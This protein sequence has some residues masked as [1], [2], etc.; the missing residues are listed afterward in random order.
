MRFALLVAGL[1]SV[2]SVQDD[3]DGCEST[4]KDELPQP[5][6]SLANN[7]PSR[8]IEQANQEFRQDNPAIAIHNTCQTHSNFRIFKFRVLFNFVYQIIYEIKSLQNFTLR[9]I[10]NNEI[11]QIYG[12]LQI[13]IQYRLRYNSSV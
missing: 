10:F 1:Y 11:F 3:G 4:S 6:G 13:H 7:I 12:M 9:Y 2:I 8:A 5:K